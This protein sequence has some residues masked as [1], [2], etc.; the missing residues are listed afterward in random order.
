MSRKTSILVTSPI[1]RWYVN[2][3]NAYDKYSCYKGENFPQAIEMQLSK[4]QK[5][6]HQYFVVFMESTSNFQDFERKK[7]RLKAQLFPKL[8]TL[9]FLV[10]QCLKGEVLGDTLTLNLL[11]ARKPA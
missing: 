9:K 8:L 3:L 10:A 5:T 4:K 1:L 11:T 7:M 2:T 6:V